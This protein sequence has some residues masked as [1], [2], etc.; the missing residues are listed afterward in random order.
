MRTCIWGDRVISAFRDKIVQLFQD[1]DA[2]QTTHE[3]GRLLEDLIE[4]ILSNIDGIENIERDVLNTF[5]SEEVDV[6]AYNNKSDRGLPFVPFVFLV[7]CKNW[8]KAVGSDEIAWFL[9]KLRNRACE[10]GILVAANGISGDPSFINHSQHTLSHALH[11]GIKILVVT[12][13]EL[14]RL[15]SSA[16][17]VSLLKTKLCRLTVA[18][19]IY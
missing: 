17:F 18:G 15:Q 8:S 9:T 11:D 13:V 14:E 7:E 16:E 5:A 3:K 12:R 6:A 10:F 19:A 1:A 4:Y 2:A